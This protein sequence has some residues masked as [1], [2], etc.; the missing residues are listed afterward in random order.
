MSRGG[1]TIGIL[2]EMAGKVDDL[3]RKLARAEQRITQSA[4]K[5]NSTKA[6]FK[7]GVDMRGAESQLGKQTRELL[8]RTAQSS[9]ID[10]I[11]NFIATLAPKLAVGLIG[12]RAA[13]T[14]VEVLNAISSGN[15]A[16]RRGDI[17]GE[18]SAEKS[19]NDLAGN[20]PLVGLLGAKIRER[21]TGEQEYIINLK[22]LTEQQ[23][24]VTDQMKIRADRARGEIQGG[25]DRVRQ[26]DRADD[27]RGREPLTVSRLAAQNALEDE[28]RRQETKVAAID[29]DERTTAGQANREL[30]DRL[31]GEVSRTRGAEI[32]GDRT[33]RTREFEEQQERDRD[34]GERLRA[35]IEQRTR[36]RRRFVTDVAVNNLDL[37]REEAEQGRAEADERTRQNRARRTATTRRFTD[38]Q[39]RR[40][41]GEADT[42]IAELQ[43]RGQTGRAEIASI[44]EEV[45]R[46]IA[47]AAG[48]PEL[49]AQVQ[50]RGTAQLQG[51]QREIE[52]RAGATRAEAVDIRG[53][54]LLNRFGG[55]TQDPNAETPQILKG[56]ILKTL[57][58][59]RDKDF[60]AKTV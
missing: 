5:I 53:T 33:R 59:I 27:A 50:R 28:L 29:L 32:A 37:A 21:I 6:E 41:E 3:E 4:T 15:A 11:Q 8:R 52:R 39:I 43:G 46:G 48:D 23:E 47:D 20:I 31:G 17:E 16:R 44:A 60:S 38:I 1:S 26:L 45:R 19:L 10:P 13:T 30:R 49:E 2:M 36:A 18:V 34:E 22:F 42:R 35:T 7:V 58:Q 14:G 9:G 40:Q 25:E 56:D 24:K 55:S 51:L 57:Q 54:D 12:V